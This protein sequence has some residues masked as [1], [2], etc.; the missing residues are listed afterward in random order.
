[1][2]I[3][4]GAVMGFFIAYLKVQ[5]FIAT[6]AGM[7]FARGM[8]YLISDAEI[9]IYH[10]TWRLLAGT[11]I[12]IPGLADPVTKTGSY[13]TVLVVIALA[14]LAVGSVHRPFHALRAHGVRDGRQ[15][16]GQ[17][18]VRAVDGPARRP[19]EDAG[20]HAQRVL[21]GAGRPRVQHL[22]RVRSRDARAGHGADG[23]RGRGHRRHGVDRRRRLRAG[24][25]VRGAHHRP[26]PEP[27]PVQRPAQLVVDEHLH[28][29]ADA[30]VHRRPEPAE[31][32]QHAPA[33]ERRAR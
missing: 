6:L 10:P 23:H 26:H 30:A 1:M 24:G 4:I 20:L 12:L 28:R 33:G 22:R 27:H 7:W 31:H 29:V 25:A 13:I 8:C 32:A 17:R 21:L 15:Q 18:A 19:D 5:P 14:V 3:S 11:K 9:R 16:R 2:G